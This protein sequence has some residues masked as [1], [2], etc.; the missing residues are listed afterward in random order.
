MLALHQ[1]SE[2][3]QGLPCA[4]VAYPGAGITAHVVVLRESGTQQRQAKP[5]RRFGGVRIGDEQLRA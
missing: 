2:I 3:K 4:T 1:V 5:T